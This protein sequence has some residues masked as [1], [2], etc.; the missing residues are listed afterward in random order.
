MHHQ[1]GIWMFSSGQFLSST[2]RVGQADQAFQA[3]DTLPIRGKRAPSR[4]LL[5]HMPSKLMRLH[6]ITWTLFHFTPIAFERW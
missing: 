1:G 3:V 5:S 4:P 6:I 2:A